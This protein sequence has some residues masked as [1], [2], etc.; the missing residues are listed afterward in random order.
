MKDFNNC[1]MYKLIVEGSDLIYI[2]HTCT[3]LCERLYG[4]R[5][6]KCSS[7]I[8]FDIGIVKIILIEKYPCLNMYDACKREQE[9]ID[10]HKDICINF[11]MAYRTEEYIKEYRKQY[12]ESNK[13]KIKASRKEYREKNIDKITERNNKFYESNKDKIKVQQKQYR[14]RKKEMKQM[15]ENDINI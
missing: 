1:K 13:D 9:L 5:E 3:E 6:M 2:G 8:L 14:L 15:A 4:H 11:A 10:E 12:Q 7:K